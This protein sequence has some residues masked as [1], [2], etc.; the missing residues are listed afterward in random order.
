M[1]VIQIV[2]LVLFLIMYVLMLVFSEKRPY[3][4]S[5]A[6]IIFIVL[7][8]INFIVYQDNSFGE[9]LGAT[10][11]TAFTDLSS[12]NV[13]LMI[14]GTMG[15]VALFIESKMPSLMADIIINKV[16]NVKWAM[17]GLA[18]F[19]SLISAFIDNVATVLMVA[20]VAMT[21]CKKLEI[22][23]VPGIIAIAISSN[24]QG[25]ATLVGDTTSILLGQETGMNFVDFFWLNGRP[26]LFF[27]VQAGA[28]TSAF[29][30]L[31]IFRKYTQPLEQVEKTKVTDYFPSFL[32]LGIIVCLIIASFFTI[33][34]PWLDSLKN[35]I[36]CITIFL[37]GFIRK[38]I[39]TKES[40]KEVTKEAVKSLDFETLILLFGLFIVIGG[41]GAL[42]IIGKIGDAFNNI[43]HSLN[44]SPNATIFV[45]YTM[46]VFVSVIISAF[47]DNIPYVM[48]M[49]PVIT[50]LL[51][52]LGLAPGDNKAYLLYFG[53]LIGATLGGNLTPVGASANITGIGMLRK[54]GYEVKT[55][56]FMKISVPFTLV[57]VFTG[58]GLCYLIWG[59]W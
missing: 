58:W 13:L 6:A 45:L 43:A 22:N 8:V 16:P 2:A 12:W 53:L 33:P 44:M 11:K 3:I 35:G 40:K 23:P 38:L 50:A 36:I 9:A 15:V 32:L 54:E 21:V 42:G 4:T 29:V 51:P 25:A 47:V 19:A 28:L 59:I 48:T 18:L 1:N 31:F 52:G 14:A 55:S 24:L 56:T 49:L 20:P 57:A 27:I 46:I 30:L 37:I 26:N 10:A 17:V 39:K 5:G 34:V 41:L 7:M